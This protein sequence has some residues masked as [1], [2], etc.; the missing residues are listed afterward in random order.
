MK[1]QYKSPEDLEA[2]RPQLSVGKANFEIVGAEDAVSKSGNEMIKLSVKVWDKDGNSGVLFDYLPCNVAFKIRSLCLAIGK[3]DWYAPDFD[4]QAQM[5]V[6]QCGDCG[7]AI[8]KSQD[9]QYPDRIK[10]KAY[11]EADEGAAKID[12]STKAV[13][14]TAD[15]DDDIPF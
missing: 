1:Y 2:E 15:F 5:L 10:I 7:L 6:G 3:P 13:S 11:Y 12:K 14:S 9:P 4:L 8:E